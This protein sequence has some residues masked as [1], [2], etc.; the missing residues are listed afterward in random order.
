[1]NIATKPVLYR[2]SFQTESTTVLA[3]GVRTTRNHTSAFEILRLGLKT[4]TLAL[5]GVGLNPL[6]LAMRPS[7][8]GHEL[9]VTSYV[10]SLWT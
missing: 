7:H 10:L 4:A 3:C 8:C 2:K 9:D 1:M 5:A 6:A